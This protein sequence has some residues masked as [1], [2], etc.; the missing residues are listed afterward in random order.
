MVRG[1]NPCSARLEGVQD[2]RVTMLI[3][4]H[5]ASPHHKKIVSV[6]NCNDCGVASGES[7][8]TRIP[9]KTPQEAHTKPPVITPLGTLIYQR[10]DWEPP[11][12]PLGYHRQSID[13]A[14]DGAWV[15]EPDEPLCKHLELRAAE[16]GSCG[17]CRVKRRCRLIKS[18]VG[19]RT[20]Q[21]CPKREPI[22]AG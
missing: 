9:P 18:Y 11:P 1:L 8:Q 4:G 16:K 3:C 13:L 22:D 12:L 15:L 5:T 7:R 2:G 19:P 14:D 21:T 10:S 6:E 20:C 17:Y